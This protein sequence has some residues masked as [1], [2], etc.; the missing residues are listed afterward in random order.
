[1][2]LVS[3]RYDYKIM[4]ICNFIVQND[5]SC[6]ELCNWNNFQ[7]KMHVSVNIIPFNI[8]KSLRLTI[9]V[10]LQFCNS[11]YLQNLYNLSLI[12]RS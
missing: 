9:I 10:L 7:L 5:Q 6:Q 11:L 3:G 2:Q 8:F 12:Q 1:M 4:R